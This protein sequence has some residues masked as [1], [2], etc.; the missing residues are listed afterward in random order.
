MGLHII[1]GDITKM[2]VDAI[3]N[4]TN[5]HMLG[6]AG[7]DKLIHEIGG[8]KFEL[9]C[10]AL[11]DKVVPGEAVY[12][13]AYNMDC[14]YVIHTVSLDW[15]G[16]IEGEPA[17][18]RSCYRSSLELANELECRSVAFP[19]IAAGNKGCPISVALKCA[20]KSINDFF[21]SYRDMEVTLVLHGED[22]KQRADDLFGDLDEYISQNYR[23]AKEE[24]TPSLKALLSQ[25]DESF[26]DKIRRFMKEKGFKRYCDVY[27]RAYMTRANF[28]KI[29]KGKTKKPTIQ[30]CV[31]LAMAMELSYDE[32]VELLAS[33]GMTFSNSS[34]F[35]ILI[36]YY[37]KKGY[38]D[39]MDIDEKLIQR[40]LP[41][42]YNEF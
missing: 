13:N 41:P 3:V 2:K 18:I 23:P 24:P 9:E 36:S 4:S 16:G 35:D 1:E 34:K 37:I 32:T 38:Y 8:W 6:Y 28:N 5:H 15:Q 39:L 11:R 21:N 33:V 31:K 22:I 27:N 42:L 17:V 12:T 30:T 29:M 7:V 26:A 20:V 25:P 19:L 10:E 14:K 40:H